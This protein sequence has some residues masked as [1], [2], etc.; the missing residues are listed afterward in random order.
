MKAIMQTQK[1]MFMLKD[2]LHR[3]R[4]FTKTNQDNFK[5]CVAVQY[6]LISN[7]TTHI[8]GLKPMD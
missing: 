5:Y 1:Q 7:V 6:L 3:H 4:N 2:K 8:Y